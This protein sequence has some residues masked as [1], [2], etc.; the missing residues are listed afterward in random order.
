MAGDEVEDAVEDEAEDEVG[1]V[2]ITTII[3]TAV[4]ITPHDRTIINLLVPSEVHRHLPIHYQYQ[5][6]G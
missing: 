4:V 6:K 1:E 3:T 2:G 5:T